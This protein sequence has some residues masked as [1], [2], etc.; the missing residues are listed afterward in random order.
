MNT[1]TL[2]N[3]NPGNNSLSV[4]A[5][6]TVGKSPRAMVFNKEVSKLYVANYDANPNS[7]SIS[8]ISVSNNSVTNIS[9]DSSE[10]VAFAYD[11]NG[12][13]LYVAC[14]GENYVF[15]IDTTNDTVIKKIAVKNRPSNVILNPNGKFVYVANFG[16][17]TI[18]VIETAGNT[19]ISTLT[20]GQGPLGMA[21][22]SD[23]NVLFVGN[24]CP[25]TLS[26]IDIEH[27]VVLPQS[28]TTG[29]KN[30][31]PFDIAVISEADGYS[32][33]YIAKE[34]FEPRTKGFCPNLG[35]SS[36]EVSVYSIQKP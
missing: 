8:V 36:L 25:R 22:N 14:E 5:N 10:P 20:V 28:L 17:T 15:A 12:N 27:N 6:I 24:Y 1:V 23:N 11:G 21:L 16:D 19:V 3:V 32:K 31:N 26:V 34:S 2:L 7:N 33:V 4:G 29:E 35:N 18:S 9:L 13:R 30:G